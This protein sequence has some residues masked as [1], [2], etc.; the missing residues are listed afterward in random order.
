MQ[1]YFQRGLLAYAQHCMIFYYENTKVDIILQSTCSYYICAEA[2][3]SLLESYYLMSYL[4]PNLMF[5]AREG[6]SW[7]QME[8]KIPVTSSFSVLF[9]D[10]RMEPA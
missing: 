2:D 5:R 10:R 6:I 8:A 3:F 4:S 7:E 9:L 1:H